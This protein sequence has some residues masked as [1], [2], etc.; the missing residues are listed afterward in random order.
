M[1][2][3]VEHGV[4]HCAVCIMRDMKSSLI[5]LL[6]R[7]FHQ[8]DIQCNTHES[9]QQASPKI[10]NPARDYLDS[11]Q[12]KLRKR[13]R[14]AILNSCVI[15]PNS[16]TKRHLSKWINR[17]LALIGQC[18]DASI[19][20]LC[21]KPN[22]PDE[23][24]QPYL[25]DAYTKL[26]PLIGL[27]LDCSTN[28]QISENILIWLFYHWFYVCRIHLLRGWLLRV[29][30]RRHFYGVPF[31]IHRLEELLNKYKS[32]ALRFS[33][34]PV[35]RAWFENGACILND[36]VTMKA[37][38]TC[39]PLLARGIYENMW[40]RFS[41][42]HRQ[43]KRPLWETTVHFNQ[44]QV[45]LMEAHSRAASRLLINFKSYMASVL[46]RQ[47]LDSD[48]E[49]SASELYDTVQLWSTVYDYPLERY[50]ALAGLISISCIIIV[51]L[52]LFASLR[53]LT[54]KLRYFSPVVS[55]QENSLGRVI[56]FYCFLAP[57]CVYLNL[58]LRLL[59]A[60]ILV[61]NYL[62]LFPHRTSHRLLFTQEHRVDRQQ[63]FTNGF[64]INLTWR[65]FEHQERRVKNLFIEL[66][67]EL[68]RR[69]IFLPMDLF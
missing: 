6:W 30:R 28:A 52:F 60:R 34:C 12:W 7:E 11:S 45:V 65:A 29:P 49:P 48:S 26:A 15:K 8:R 47:R 59:W 20:D 23:F 42:R 41:G 16:D 67:T 3:I 18:V 21:M 32:E 46:H 35:L 54:P 2:Q 37:C 25:A 66:R 36:L 61:N 44:Q 68:T 10:I 1:G 56:C 19:F 58:E 63:L 9:K 39:H 33:S 69:G 22:E 55:S 50:F 4:V 51:L 24:F 5:F 64:Q 62:R 53:H 14:E 27:L 40:N 31:E 43:T 13:Y 57:L 38:Q 17:Q